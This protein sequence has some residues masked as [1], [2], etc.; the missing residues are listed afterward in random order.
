MLWSFWFYCPIPWDFPVKE[1]NWQTREAQGMS[2][3]Q[4]G[5]STHPLRRACGAKTGSAA[6]RDMSLTAPQ[7]L[8]RVNWG[9]RNGLVSSWACGR[10]RRWYHQ[11][12]GAKVKK[13]KFILGIIKHWGRFWTLSLEVFKTSQSPVFP[14]P[15]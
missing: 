2:L 15:D 8:W 9:N 1:R 10:Y 4:R 7:R 3:K 13:K 6:N 5:W 14:P 12:E 11:L